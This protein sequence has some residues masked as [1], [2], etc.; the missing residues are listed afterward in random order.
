MKLAL[1][2]LSHEG[3]Q[4]RD[5]LRNDAATS[6][7]SCINGSRWG[8]L[9]LGGVGGDGEEVSEGI[10]WCDCVVCGLTEAMELFWY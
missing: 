3:G 1:G 10:H 6:A 2:E 8:G 4:K 7:A 5:H 9:G